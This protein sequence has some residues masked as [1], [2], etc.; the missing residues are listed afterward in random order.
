[1]E[2]ELYHFNKNHDELGRFASNGGASKAVRKSAKIQGKIEKAEN[3]INK[4]KGKIDK[5]TNSYKGSKRAQKLEMTRNR[6][7][8]KKSRYADRVAKAQTKKLYEK[9]LNMFDKSAL[10]KT[11]DLD[12]RISKVTAKQNRWKQKVNNLNYKNTKLQRKVDKYENKLTS[13]FD[14][15]TI[16][17]GRMFLEEM[18][19]GG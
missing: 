1:M 5:I 7:E 4:N 14:Q 8:I 11:Y 16:D 13:S 9:R 3:K 12:R 6:L 17:A 10:R 15:E 2:R 18:K 19:K